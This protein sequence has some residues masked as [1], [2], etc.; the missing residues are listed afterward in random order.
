MISPIVKDG[1]ACIRIELLSLAVD[2]LSENKGRTLDN[3]GRTFTDGR[4]F[5]TEDVIR[6]AKKLYDFVENTPLKQLCR[7]ARNVTN[8]DS[9]EIEEEG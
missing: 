6:E 1:D 8:Y 7:A 2:I 3:E 5:T 9:I 4:A